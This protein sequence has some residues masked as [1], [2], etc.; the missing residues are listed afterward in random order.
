MQEYKDTAVEELLSPLGLPMGFYK[1]SAFRKNPVPEVPY[2]AYTTTPE[3][4][5]GADEI[6]FYTIRTVTADIY[7]KEVTDRLCDDAEQALKSAEWEKDIMYNESE[8]VY[9][10]S[11]KFDLIKFL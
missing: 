3:K 10:I 1:F 8:A 9:M 7:V 6:N 11:Y 2:I 4:A 5:G